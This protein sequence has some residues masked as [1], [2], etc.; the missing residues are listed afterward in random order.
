[1]YV[2]FYITMSIRGDFAHHWQRLE[3][4]LV[5][6]TGEGSATNIFGQSPGGC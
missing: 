2:T 4:F 1:M 6:I 3:K 5:V